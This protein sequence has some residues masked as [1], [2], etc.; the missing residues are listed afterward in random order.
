M[1]P[2]GPPLERPKPVTANANSRSNLRRRANQP[3]SARGKRGGPVNRAYIFVCSTAR[4]DALD[5]WPRPSLVSWNP[6]DGRTQPKDVGAVRSHEEVNLE[7]QIPNGS[8]SGLCYFD[9]FAASSRAPR[10]RRL[11]RQQNHYAQGNRDAM[12]LGQSSL[13]PA[14]RRS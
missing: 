13:R 4:D 3:S 5:L 12:A 6:E 9:F 1:K 14:P 7:G 2:L 8:C 11:R 10:Q